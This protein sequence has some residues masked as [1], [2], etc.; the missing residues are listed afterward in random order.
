MIEILI[1]SLIPFIGSI[2][3]TSMGFGNGVLIMAILPFILPFG[4]AVAFNQISC[5]FLTVLVVSKMWRKIRWSVLIPILIP[6]GISTILFTLWSFSFDQSILKML[7]GVVF[8]ILVLVFL[9]SKKG[10]SIKPTPLKGAVM[11]VISGLSNGFTGISGPP[12]AMYLRPSIENND[13]YI[14]TIQC[15]FLFQSTI[16]L[17]SRMGLGALDRGDI[18]FLAIVLVATFLGSVIGR[19]INGKVDSAKMQRYVYIFVGLYGVYVLF[20]ELI[21][22]E[23]I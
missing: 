17:L 10:I 4:K 7:L 22:I 11:G 8:I 9:L 21:Y 12:A 15:F 18:G 1:F 3:Q 2:L 16:G 13:E 14:A 23:L 20:S 19:K 5:L 6:M